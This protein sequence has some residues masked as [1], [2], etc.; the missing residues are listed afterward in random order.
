MNTYIRTPLEGISRAPGRG[1]RPAAPRTRFITPHHHKS[2][3]Y[4][5]KVLSFA[6]ERGRK[7]TAKEKREKQRKGRSQTTMMLSF[8]KRGLLVLA[9]AVAASVS[10]GLGETTQGED[11]SD[12]PCVGIRTQKACEDTKASLLSHCV[13]CES[14]AVPSQCVTPDVAEVCTRDE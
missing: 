11:G 4:W 6:C 9:L 3:F 12:I 13:W 2:A 10:H 14:K 5:V 1:R 7:I 8:S